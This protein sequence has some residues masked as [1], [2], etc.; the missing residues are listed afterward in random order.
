M[1]FGK[2]QLCL[3]WADITLFCL[4]YFLENSIK[5]KGDVFFIVIFFIEKGRFKRK[6]REDDVFF[7]RAT[8]Q[9][10]ATICHHWHFVQ[11]GAT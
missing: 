7:Y 4:Q 1:H 8:Q 3:S 11:S 10:K 2:L 5:L 6:E 9:V